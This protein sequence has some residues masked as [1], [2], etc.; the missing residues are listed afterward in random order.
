MCRSATRSASESTPR[1]AASVVPYSGPGTQ[2]KN[3]TIFRRSA[4]KQDRLTK[5]DVSQ[6]R[7]SSNPI[8]K[9][10]S[11]SGLLALFLW[12]KRQIFCKFKAGVLKRRKEGGGAKKR[13]M[14]ELLR[15]LPHADLRFFFF[16][17]HMGCENCRH[18]CVP[19][20][21]NVGHCLT[22]VP[23]WMWLQDPAGNHWSLISGLSSSF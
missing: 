2:D 13:S 17:S 12:T 10:H 16:F 5:G 1:H 23:W 21:G 22:L 18:H 7:K 15:S 6:S 19:E 14:S 11:E 4:E 8:R 9:K 3:G 20:V